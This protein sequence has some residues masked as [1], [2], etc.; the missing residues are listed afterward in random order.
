MTN[1]QSPEANPVRIIGSYLSPYTRK[2]L[3]VL[4]LKGIAYMIDPVI[5]FYG[6]DTFT[7]LSPVRR[8][9][10]L[11]DGEFTI[12]DS[13]IVI[14][15]LEER[16]PEP[17]VYPKNPTDRARVRWLEEYADSRLQEVCMVHFTNQLTIRPL[18]WGEEPNQEL[19]EFAKSEEFPNVLNY[20]EGE[21]PEAGFLFENISVADI[22]IASFFR[23]PSLLEYRIDSNRWPVAA[24][25]VDRVLE[26]D[27]FQKLL[28]FEQ[29][30][31]ETMPA[32]HWKALDEMGAPLIPKRESVGS[33]T[34]RRGMMELR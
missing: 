5:A 4:D 34:P 27:S 17:S 12:S 9:P 21:L 13:T 11:I 6:N 26:L 29:K 23:N 10:V 1:Q 3:V 19:V 30:L 25:F 16:Y 28:P 20:L 33:D 2:A 32:D 22:A 14:E 15:Y 8:V 31:M 24:A 7:K 18:V